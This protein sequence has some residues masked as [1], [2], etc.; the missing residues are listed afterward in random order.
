VVGSGRKKER[1]RADVEAHAK[2]LLELGLDRRTGTG[3]VVVLCGSNGCLVATIAPAAKK[4]KITCIGKD[5][6]V[7]SNWLPPTYDQI[8]ARSGKSYH[9]WKL[10]TMFTGTGALTYA[11]A[12]GDNA[13]HA[14]KKAAVAMTFMLELGHWGCKDAYD[15]EHIGIPHAQWEQVRKCR[16]DLAAR[17]LQPQYVDGKEFWNQSTLL[18]RLEAFE[19]LDFPEDATDL[20]A[21][22]RKHSSRRPQ[23]TL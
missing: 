9:A 12:K 17:H 13:F 1:E 3:T 4:G 22:L 23:G 11:M 15:P 6:V 19:T 8:F 2:A 21:F 5:E 14:A 10:R 7:T 16:D 20:L 18:E